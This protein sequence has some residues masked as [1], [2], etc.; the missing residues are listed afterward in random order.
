MRKAKIV[1]TLGPAVDSPD[2]QRKLIMAGMDVAR[3]NLSH[4]SHEEHLGRI[5]S[6]RKLSTELGKHIPILLDTKGPEIR[7]GTFENGHITVTKGDIFTLTSQKIVGTQSR[8]SISYSLLPQE[9]SHGD[10]ILLDDGLVEFEVKN[11]DGTEIEC[12]VIEGG[13]LGDR[14]GVNIPG[15]HINIPPLSDADKADILFAVQNGIDIIAISFVRQGSDIDQIRDFI[16]ANGGNIPIIAKIENHEGIANLSDILDKADG[17]L[18][19][20]G[21][22]GVELPAEEVPIIQKRIIKMCRAV[23]KPVITATQMLD[24]MIRNPHP[25]RAE[26]SDV[27]NAIM[28]GTDAIMLSGETAA[29]KYPVE[30]LKTMARIAERTEEA[31]CNEENSYFRNI[32][33]SS[34]VTDAI[35][36][37]TVQVATELNA[38]A[39]ITATQSGWTARMVSK[40]RPKAPI[41]AVTYSEPVARQLNLIWGVTPLLGTVTTATDEMIDIAVISAKNAGLV[42]AGDIVVI[43]AG[44]PVGVPGTTNM[45]KVHEIQN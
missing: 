5:N 6:L 12:E 20:R 45:L 1:C 34:A 21:D 4:G 24:S 14:K 10:H 15:K 33:A 22:M 43:T 27:A 7:L 44:V 13:S 8:A 9:I 28:D 38:K 3:I 35:G 19:A 26:V 37:A 31:M 30:A 41:I 36:H 42:E 39:I 18:V 11:V 32:V 17:L 16:K 40:Y 2:I 29:G 23:G 25:T